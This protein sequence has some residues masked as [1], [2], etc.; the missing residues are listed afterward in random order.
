MDPI[1]T[2]ALLPHHEHLGN[3]RKVATIKT[4]NAFPLRNDPGELSCAQM[5]SGLGVA[6]AFYAAAKAWKRGPE[7]FQAVA[8]S[9]HIPNHPFD[10]DLFWEWGLA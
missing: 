3:N 9:H 6:A 5:A 7:Q 2:L 4:L 10:L 1:Y 8:E